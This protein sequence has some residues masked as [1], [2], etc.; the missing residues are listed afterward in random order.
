MKKFV[1]ALTFV[2]AVFSVP[3][4]ADTQDFNAYGAGRGLPYWG[5]E[6]L[7][8]TSLAFP[9][10]TLNAAGGTFPTLQLDAPGYYGAINY[11]LLAGYGGD[12]TIDFNAAQSAFAIDLRDFQGYGGTDTITVYGADD[13]TVLATYY[14]GLNGSIATFTDTGESGPIGAVNL[15]VVSGENWSGILQ[16]VTYSAPTPVPEPGTLALFATGLLGLAGLVR[17]K[18]NL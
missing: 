9:A 4:F 15:S 6:D 1:V 8:I 3:A 17:R 5:A 13:T 12:L 10:F 2:L 18:L 16:S 11:E 7:G 14:M